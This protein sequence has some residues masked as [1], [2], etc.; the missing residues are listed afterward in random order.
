M[1]SYLVNT[2]IQVVPLNIADPN[3]SIVNKAI[4]CIQASGYPFIVTPFET[5]VNATMPQTLEL[6]AQLQQLAQDNGA[7][8]LIINVRFHSRYQQDCLFQDKLG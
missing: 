8:E 1:S 6:L 3:Y 4:A 5:V 2:G 7:T